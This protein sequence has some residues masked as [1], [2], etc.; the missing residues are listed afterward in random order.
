VQVL[1]PDGKTVGYIPA[2]NL[3]AAIQAGYKQL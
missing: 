1:H 3:Q 2:A